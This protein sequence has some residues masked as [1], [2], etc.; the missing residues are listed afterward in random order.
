MQRPSI[1]VRSEQQRG[2]GSR[3]YV[4]RE[5]QAR[6]CRVLEL[7]ESRRAKLELVFGAEA[8]PAFAQRPPR[9][10]GLG[11]NSMPD[12]AADTF[13]AA[14]WSGRTAAQP[15]TQMPAGPPPAARSRLAAGVARVLLRAR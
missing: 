2:S 5:Y 13:A 11:D 1:N 9:L 15:G 10:C 8:G 3:V 7:H 4:C 6:L 12:A 14:L